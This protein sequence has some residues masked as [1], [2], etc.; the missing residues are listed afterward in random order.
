[1]LF[2]SEMPEGIKSTVSQG[3]TNFSG[4]QKQRLSIARALVRKPPVFVFDDS[5][6]ALDFR[7]DANLRK[8]MK[9]ITGRATLIIIAQRVSTIMN[10]DLIIV[11]NEGRI[12]GQGSHEDL[13]ANCK[14]YQEI[15]ESQLSVEEYSVKALGGEAGAQNE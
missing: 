8:A 6:S 7:T 11:M 14:V 4:G 10:S 13:L 9:S 2:R 15:L 12:V 1:M 3:G 5:F